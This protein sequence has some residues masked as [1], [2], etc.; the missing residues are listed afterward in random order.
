MHLGARN[1][2][3]WMGSP[4]QLKTFQMTWFHVFGL[5]ELVFTSRH[6]STDG[7]ALNW[8]LIVSKPHFATLSLSKVSIWRCPKSWKPIFSIIRWGFLETLHLG[9]PPILGNM[10][11]PVPPIA[12]QTEGRWTKPGAMG[13]PGFYRWAVRRV[14]YLRAKSCALPYEF[15]NLQLGSLRL[16]ENHYDLV[17]FMI[18]DSIT[19]QVFRVLSW[20]FL[21]LF[22]NWQLGSWVSYSTRGTLTSMGLCM[23]A[24][25]TGA[26]KNTK[27]FSSA[28][29]RWSW[30]IMTSWEKTVKLPGIQR[31][32]RWLLSWLLEISWTG[33]ARS[34]AF[35]RQSEGG[36]TPPQANEFLWIFSTLLLLKLLMESWKMCERESNLE[37]C[38]N[39]SVP[40]FFFAPN[41]PLVS[42]SSTPCRCCSTSPW[43]VLRPGPRWT[44]SGPG[45]NFNWWCW[46]CWFE[47]W[48]EN[49][50]SSQ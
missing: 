48:F 10:L 21:E 2:S 40:T 18:Y 24:W 1:P 36:W 35:H 47:S 13:V 4:P 15:D 23:A 9:V 33:S 3:K 38:L 19:T 34:P 29:S 16:M 44:S 32:L 11:P 22:R 6:G 37:I 26:C 39:E 28:W 5:L 20:D 25:T 50:Q 7:V 8:H 31:F 42:P 41:H 46:G 27:N 49:Q 43:M 30:K 14:P 45:G 17:W 12:S